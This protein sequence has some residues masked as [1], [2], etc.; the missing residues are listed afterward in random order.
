MTRREKSFSL[1]VMDLGMNER[2][3]IFVR[4]IGEGTDVLRP[5][6]AIVLP[7]GLYRLEQPV[8][9]VPEDEEW[10]FLPGTTVSCEPQTHEGESILVAF[11]HVKSD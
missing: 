11:M 3:T 6:Q 8:D 5:A 10:Q 1:V 9:Y 2:T 4:L 7:N